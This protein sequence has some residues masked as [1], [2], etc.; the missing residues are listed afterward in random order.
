MWFANS[1]AYVTDNVWQTVI[2][3][4]CIVAINFYIT[5]TAGPVAPGFGFVVGTVASIV[6][7]LLGLLKVGNQKNDAL[8]SLTASISKSL[9]FL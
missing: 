3:F 5:V 6:G 1:V 9:E 8:D 7:I 2:V 4:L